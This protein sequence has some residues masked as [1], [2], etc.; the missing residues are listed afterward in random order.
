[1]PIPK[2]TKEETKQEYIARFMSDETMKKEYPDEKQRLAIA[3]SEFREKQNDL[4]SGGLADNLTLEDIA[5]KHNKSL[6]EIQSQFEKGLKVELEH[7]DNE[8]IAGEIAKDHI[9]EMADYYDKLAKMEKQNAK[10]FPKIY[11]CKHMQAGV[12]DYEDERILIENETLNKMM[13]SFVGKPVYIIHTN[14]NL[15]KLKE[16]ADG[17]VSD[18]FYNEKD[19]WYWLKFIII[20]DEA[21]DKIR[22]GWSVSNAYLPTR[23]GSSGSWHNVPYD[24][25]I[26]EAE[27]SHLAIVP[28]P[29]YEGAEIFT[30]EQYKVYIE[31]KENQLKELQNSKTIKKEKA[32]GIL[33]FW[34]KTK[35]AKENEEELLN[36][37]VEI[38]GIDVSVK[39]LIENAKKMKK[40]E[41][42]EGEE[43]EK[44]DK[45]KLNEDDELEIDGAKVSVKEL[46]NMYKK[47]KKNE[48]EEEKKKEE[49]KEKEDEEEKKK[50]EEKENSKY[51]K[52]LKNS[53]KKGEFQPLNY[54]TREDKLTRGKSR[55]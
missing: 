52:E 47:M 54:E 28:N 8:Q 14:V 37:V 43:E 29:R 5:K 3:Y 7:T 21:H 22:Q 16:E 41:E 34:N 12:C 38:D 48:D 46:K 42:K 49:E 6:K 2:P 1:M 10:E 31:Q 39:E 15:E 55:Y 9:Y 23:S 35:L 4:I 50:E 24:R 20:E 13:P 27:Y 32:G 53:V 44:E 40:N 30:P 33:M 25:E 11:Y 26:L 19:G 18:S 36:A 45:A 51:Y 17:Y